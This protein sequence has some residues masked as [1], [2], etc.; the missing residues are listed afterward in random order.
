MANDDPQQQVQT[1]LST[2]GVIRRRPKW[3][4]VAIIVIIAIII[5]AGLLWYVIGSMLSDN[6]SAKN[7]KQA[8]TAGLV[9]SSVC[10][11]ALIDQYNSAVANNSLTAASDIEADIKGS[12]NYRGDVNCDY[13]LVNYYLAIGDSS[14]ATN[15]LQ[16]LKWAYNNGQNYSTQFNP[17][18]V[19]AVVLQRSIDTLTTQQK[20]ARQQANQPIPSEVTR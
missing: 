15:S 16:D 8:N 17:S 1:P 3:R 11:S 14:S 5:A 20:E 4:K 18:A 6:N 9:A 10:G 19:S 7:E 12:K 13:M 2:A